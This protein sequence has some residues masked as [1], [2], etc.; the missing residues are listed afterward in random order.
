M[1]LLKYHVKSKNLPKLKRPGWIN[2]AFINKETKQEV[3]EKN[4]KNKNL[5]FKQF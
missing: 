5:S 4:V 3:N 2:T 1:Y